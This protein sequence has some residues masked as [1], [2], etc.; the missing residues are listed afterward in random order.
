MILDRTWNKNE[1]KLVISY[2]DKEG[3]RQFYQKYFHH[4]K[5]YEYDENG[6]VDTWDG[7]K[8][9]KVYKDTTNYTPNEFDILEFMYELPEDLNKVMH[10]QYFP[11]LYFFDIETKF[12]PTSFPD[13]QKALHQVTAISLV[14]PDM[15]CIVYGLR[16]LSEEQIG[17]LRSRYLD[18]INNNEFAK[19]RLKKEPK[20][21]YQYFSNE[22]DMLKH[23]FTV[24]CPKVPCLAGWNSYG[25]D[26]IY[27]VTRLTVL[28][29]QK[30]AYNILRKASPTGELTSIKVTNQQGQFL[31]KFQAPC[32]TIWLDYMEIVKQYDYTLIPYESYS[33]DWVGE[34]AVK[35][36]KI[37]YNGTLNDLYEKD[38]EWYYF[39]N[40][41]DSLIGLLIHYRLKSLESP[42]SVSS[43][44]LVPL[45]KAFGQVALTTAN[46]FNEFYQDNKRVVYNYDAIERYK[47]N[48][49]GAFCGCVAGRYQW[50]VCDDFASLYP[51]QVQTCNF[52]FEN[53]LTPEPY[54]PDSL[55]RYTPRNWTEEELENFKKDPN[56]FVSIN[57]NVYKNDKDYAFKRMQRNMKK[58]RDVYKYTGQRIESELIHEIDRLIKEKSNEK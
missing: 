8:A 24:I 26:F 48:Y 25:F 39:Y 5:T 53:I 32:H 44:T 21:L 1:Q 50:N 31:Y 49:E 30:E 28:F 18:W 34:H 37:K 3:N 56:Y 36:N 58:K 27:L 9:R 4:F 47:V 54:G 52:S 41:I 11:K 35:A 14:G 40:A 10:A 7:K 43:I 22:G 42:C 16:Q 17:L 38:I 6:D 13:P 57:G 2:I 45:P 23:F 33:L 29:G 55:G 46:V 20:V 15:S 19:S 51:S 12:D